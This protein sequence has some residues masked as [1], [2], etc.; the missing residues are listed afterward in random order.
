MKTSFPALIGTLALAGLAAAAPA[1]TDME[2]ALAEGATRMT[3][4]QIAERLAGKTVTF[5]NASSGARALVYYDGGNGTLLKLEDADEAV[6]GFYA[7]TLSDRICVGLWGDEP[8]RVRC[9]YVLLIDDMMHKF[10]V[11][12]SLRGR[13]IEEVEGNIT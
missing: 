13:V 1:Q 8:M 11:D 6:E 4:D 3:S 12:G 9:V 5:E 2:K 7:T 10:E